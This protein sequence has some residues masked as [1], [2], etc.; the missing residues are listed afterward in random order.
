MYV[1]VTH[2]ARQLGPNSFAA[3]A[4]LQGRILAPLVRS[5]G[6]WTLTEGKEATVRPVIAVQSRSLGGRH[7]FSSGAR[8]HGVSV[9]S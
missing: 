6:L 9:G 3:S 1:G 4:W 2:V 8:N 7:Y 5:N